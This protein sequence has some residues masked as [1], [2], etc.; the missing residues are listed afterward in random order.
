MKLETKNGKL[1]NK[2]K[3]QTVMKKLSQ[4]DKDKVKD[5]IVELFDFGTEIK[6]ES[7]LTMGLGFDELD[8]VE[9]VIELEKKFDCSIP[10]SQWDNVKTISD[11]YNC[12]EKNIK[13]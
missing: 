11:I 5:I 6:D 9:L 8:L 13:K 12:L 2:F 7:N 10:D 1:K 4:S 3:Q